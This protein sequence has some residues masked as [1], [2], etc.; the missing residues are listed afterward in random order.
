MTAKKNSV[1]FS[2]LVGI[3]SLSVGV[4]F[5]L[6]QKIEYAPADIKMGKVTY[7]QPVQ[8]TG[9]VAEHSLRYLS[10]N[11]A[12]Q[13]IIEDPQASLIVLFSSTLPSGFHEGK[14]VRLNGQLL[15]E[16]HFIAERAHVCVTEVKEPV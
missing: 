6:Q 7:Q 8:F 4:F 1:I 16:S 11:K 10:R 3:L 12:Y 2:L 5:W 13:F 15:D 9:R 14:T